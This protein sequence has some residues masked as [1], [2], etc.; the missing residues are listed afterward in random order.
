MIGS[1]SRTGLSDDTYP[2]AGLLGEALYLRFST[3]SGT[4]MDSTGLEKF[5]K[6]RTLL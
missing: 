5:A 3:L 2:F 6:T 1:E 4:T